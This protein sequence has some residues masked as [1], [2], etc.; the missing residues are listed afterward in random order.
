MDEERAVTKIP[1]YW[2]GV[3]KGRKSKGEKLILATFDTETK[4][5]QVFATGFYSPVLG[6]KVAI[7]HG[8]KEDHLSW[9]LEKCFSLAKKHRGRVIVSAH[10]LV[11]DIGVLLYPIMNPHGST[12]NA[13]APRTA[14][15]S[16][17]KCRTE[18]HAI[19]SKPCFATLRRG[20]DTVTIID[21]FSFF[22]MG[23]AK[24]LEM[25]GSHTKKLPKPR[26]LGRR[27]I[28]LPELRPYL[29]NDCLGGYALLEELARFHASYEVKFCLSLPMLSGMIFRSH[30]LK[31]NFI[32]PS[33]PLRKAAMLSYHGGKNAYPPKKPRLWPACYDLDINSAYPEAMRQLPDFENGRWRLIKGKEACLSHPHG[34]YRITGKLKLCPWGIL[35]DHNFQKARGPRI[36]G[37]WITGYELIEAVRSSELEIESVKGY[38]FIESFPDRKPEPGSEKQT[39]FLRFVDH[40]Y[41]MKEKATT[42]TAR[43]F[44]KLI[45]NSLYGKFVARIK[46]LNGVW[47]AGSLFDPALA[48]LITGFVRAKIHRLE[49]KY[50]ALHTATDGF[51]T[52]TEPDPADISPAL[53]KLK[54]VNFGPCL[55]LRNKLYLHYDEAGNLKKYA[56]H[57][58]QGTPD[59]LRKM[60]D[61]KNRAYKI[62]RLT[63]W[64]ESWHT[65]NR[66][67]LEIESDRILSVPI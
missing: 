9:L 6:K 34:I 48:S 22:T 2:R 46:D 51:V 17:L 54:K 42:P 23:L 25:V 49:H 47:V 61:T 56:L 14:H 29:N 18:I 21:T 27:I 12:S 15:F 63:R 28:P 8:I 44:Y 7:L 64:S 45:L 19:L 59:D 13:S 40:F 10:Y 30:Y 67:G 16:L 5:G 20:N 62:K 38:A 35:F 57:G 53:G 65:G 37:T 60:W 36:V 55:I 4:Y 52:Q 11:F 26:D 66:P 41:T 1:R 58:F 43:F 50:K 39:A 31:K 32:E 33:G 24:A 3:T